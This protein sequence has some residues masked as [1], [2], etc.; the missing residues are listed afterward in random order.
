MAVVDP[1]ALHIACRGHF[2]TAAAF[3]GAEVP[4]GVHV[5]M[6]G[7]HLAEGVAV[8]RY[9]VDHPGWYIGGFQHLV[10]IGRAQW[11]LR[12]WNDHYRIAH[13]DC[14]GNKR[15]KAEQRVFIRAGHAYHADGFGQGQHR[16]AQWR[17]MHNPLVFVG[18]G[19]VTEQARYAGLHLAV[20]VSM[21][22][23]R[24]LD[25]APREFVF[26]RRQ[27]LGDVIENLRARMRRATGPAT[28]RVSRLNRVADVLAVALAHLP[29]HAP[30]PVVH[31]AAVT[32]I[33]PRLLA[34]DKHLGRAVN[35]WKRVTVRARPITLTSIV[36][37]FLFAFFLLRDHC[38][39]VH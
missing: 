34:A 20:R 22:R 39:A 9:N 2:N 32:R 13:R 26:A 10:T 31:F 33:G 38:P 23:A 29:D 27:V 4:H 1:G 28:R 6:V 25:D 18:P 21:A 36:F 7:Q 11:R 14:R 5:V 12:R 3:E 15:D 8:A 24:L 37:V 30:L 35:R 17:A 16:A 19:R